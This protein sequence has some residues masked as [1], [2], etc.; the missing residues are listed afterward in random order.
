MKNQI[1]TRSLLS[2][3]VASKTIFFVFSVL[4]IIISLYLDII[5]YERFLLFDSAL[6]LAPVIGMIGII[7]VSIWLERTGDIFGLGFGFHPSPKLL[8]GDLFKGAQEERERINPF[9]QQELI[10]AAER[11]LEKD[12]ELKKLLAMKRTEENKAAIDGCR[13]WISNLLERF[14]QLRDCARAYS[15]WVYKSWKPYVAFSSVPR[16]LEQRKRDKEQREAEQYRLT[17]FRRTHLRVE[18]RAPF[19]GRL[20]SLVSVDGGR[21]WFL[22]EENGTGV[23]ILGTSY[24]LGSEVFDKLFSESRLLKYIQASGPINQADSAVVQMLTD[25]GLL[26]G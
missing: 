24:H 13:R 10:R 18:G 15:F 16:M 25:A 22:A 19:E 3:R 11:I 17:C 21:N 4:C 5:P 14:Y 23:E 26:G 8:F 2:P 1:N 20:Y 12:I 7:Y 9:V 6:V